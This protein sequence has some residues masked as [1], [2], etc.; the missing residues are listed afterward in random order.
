[1][2]HAETDADKAAYREFAKSFQFEPRAGLVAS[3]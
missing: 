1:L 3:R 2:P